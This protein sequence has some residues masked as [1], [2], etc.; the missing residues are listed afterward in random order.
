MS[1]KR[2]GGKRGVR[3]WGRDI[4]RQM[5]TKI[6]RE[7]RKGRGGWKSFLSAAHTWHTW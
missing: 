6:N 2:S 7:K 4:G 3:T 5:D 1:H